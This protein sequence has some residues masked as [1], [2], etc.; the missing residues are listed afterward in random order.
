[1]GAGLNLSAPGPQGRGV[2]VRAAYMLVFV[3]LAVVAS[4]SCASAVEPALESPAGA[5]DPSFALGGFLTEWFAPNPGSQ[6]GQDAALQP[7]GRIVVLTISI[8]NYLSRYLPGGTLDVSFGDGGSVALPPAGSGGYEALSVDARGRIVVIGSEEGAQWQAPEPPPFGLNRWRGMVY[9]FLP[10]GQPDPSFGTGG[11]AVISVPP[12]EGLSPG[13]T[14]TFPVAVLTAPDG[15]LTVGGEFAAVCAWEVGFEFAEFWEE[16]GTFVARL[17][18]DGSPESQFG[19]AGLV[20]THGKCKNQPGTA[21]ELFGALAQTSSDTVLS[22]AAHPEDNTWRLRFYSA[23]GTLAE[24]TTPSPDTQNPGEVELP[25]QITVLPNHDLLVGASFDSNLTTRE[26]LRRFTPQGVP[27]PSFGTSGVVVVRMECAGVSYTGACASL[28]FGVLGDGRIL[29]AG[30]TYGVAV[31]RYLPD[32]SVDG[33]F[34]GREEPGI[35]GQ[36]GQAVAVLTYRDVLV[37]KLLI[38]HGQPLVVGATQVLVPEHGAPYQTTL[39]LFQADGH[40]PETPVISPP[41]PPLYTPPPPPPPG[42]GGGGSGNTPGGGGNRSSAGRQLGRAAPPVATVRADLAAVLNP[43]ALPTISGLLRR[44]GCS[45][46]FNAPGPGILTVQWTALSTQAGQ[47][48]NHRPVIVATG[49]QSF[50]VAGRGVIVLRLTAAGRK[51]LK[52]RHTIRVADQASFRPKG[53][54][55]QRGRSEIKFQASTHLAL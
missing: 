39:A 54:A 33:S 8:D 43:R 23:T 55:M 7:D 20:S 13:S 42:P 16:S 6:E 1:M 29:I 53:G 30:R 49:A 48:V 50:G 12:P 25:E 41:D 15:S 40:E 2:R 22:L 34:G 27:D 19:T 32:G 37:K 4:A 38:V 31:M 26:V 28:P 17:R 14:A 24:T 35:G 21:R 51:L 45:L 5:L 47:H 9:R 52:K 18:A 46:S 44:G 10:D 36:S 3:V 11:K